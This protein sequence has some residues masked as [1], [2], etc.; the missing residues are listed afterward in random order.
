MERERQLQLENYAIKLQAIELEGTSLRDE[1]GRLREQLEKVKIEKGRLEDDL[2]EAKREIET[3]RE[4]ER[5]ATSR[6]NEAHYQLEIARDELS[7]R[8]EDQQKI[9]E[10]MQQVAQLRDRNKSTLMINTINGDHLREYLLCIFDI[11]ST[12]SRRISR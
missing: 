4:N 8:V 12:R 5:Q 2:E 9:E 3:T 11:L 1:I 10:L 6:A 7:M